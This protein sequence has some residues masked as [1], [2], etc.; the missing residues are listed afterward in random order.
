MSEAGAVRS[1]I[2]RANPRRRRRDRQLQ[3][4][5]DCELL[6]NQWVSAQ[7]FGAVS[8]MQSHGRRNVLIVQRIRA[9]CALMKNQ[10]DELELAKKPIGRGYPGF[11]RW[12]THTSPVTV[13]LLEPGSFRKNAEIKLR[14][15]WVGVGA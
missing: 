8:Q 9:R 3:P 4:P 11:S 7:L 13:H 2:E 12:R 15:E 1:G 5:R 10:R 14:N 6:I